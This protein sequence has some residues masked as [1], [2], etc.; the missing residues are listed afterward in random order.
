MVT[1]E[2]TAVQAVVESARSEAANAAE[3]AVATAGSFDGLKIASKNLALASFN[4]MLVSNRY[5]HASGPMKVLSKE[6]RQIASDCLTSVDQARDTIARI[7][8]VS[9]TAQGDLIGT[10]EALQDRVAE[11]QGQIAAGERRLDA[12]NEM[13]ETSSAC[14]D[15]LLQ[16]VEAVSASMGRV[17]QVGARLSEFAQ[18]LEDSFP[19]SGAPDPRRI[20]AIWDTYTMEEER[21]VHAA[22]FAG[23]PGIE[24]RVAPQ[25]APAATGGDD[26][27]D[28]MLF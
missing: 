14:A 5:S 19:V 9:E 20:D 12:M 11:A 8:S 18:L 17:E 3:M 1:A 24:T 21:E 7:T 15:S 2:L 28:D 27:I 16:M 4:S 23:V 13:R 22:V 26:D 6:V 10:T 25:A